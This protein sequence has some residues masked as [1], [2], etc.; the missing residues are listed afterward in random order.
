MA[1]LAA[2]LMACALAACS[3]RDIGQLLYNSAK[4][5]CAIG[6]LHNCGAPD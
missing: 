2:I 3:A 4:E 1:R 5:S 6:K